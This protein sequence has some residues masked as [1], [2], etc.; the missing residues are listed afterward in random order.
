ML[1]VDNYDNQ[2]G[3]SFLAGEA[4][5]LTINGVVMFVGEV[6]IVNTDVD[7]SKYSKSWMEVTCNGPDHELKQLSATRTYPYSSLT[8]SKAD[9]VIRDFMTLAGCSYTYAS[10]S[11]APEVFLKANKTFQGD[12]FKQICNA[13]GWD[14]YVTNGGVLHFFEEG[15]AG[16]HTSVD[17]L[18]IDGDDTSNILN[19]IEGEENAETVMNYIELSAGKL[20]DH[21][22]E[23]IDGWTGQIGTVVSAEYD[24]VLPLSKA[25]I[26]L[27]RSIAG[28]NQAWIEFPYGGYT[29]LGLFNPGKGY[30]WTYSE[31]LGQATMN[32]RPAF[33]DYHGNVIEWMH[34][35]ATNDEQGTTDNIYPRIWHQADFPVGQE[36]EIKELGTFTRNKKWCYITRETLLEAGTDYTTMNIDADYAGTPGY[37]RLT[38]TGGSGSFSGY[39]VGDYI[40][41]VDCTNS[42]NDGVYEIKTKTSDYIVGLWQEL[43]GDTAADATVN[44]R[45]AFRWQKIDRFMITGYPELQYGDC[46]ID[47]LTIS[48]HEVI[49]IVESAAS[50]ALYHK[51]MYDETHLEITSQKELEEYNDALLD[52]RKWPLTTAKAWAYGQTGSLYAGQ[53][54]DVHAP[55]YGIAS[56]T[57]Y[58]IIG[59][60]HMVRNKDVS[61]F[62]GANFVTYYDLVKHTA[63]GTQRVDPHRF[64]YNDAPNIAVQEEIRRRLDA[65]EL[66]IQPLD[67]EVYARLPANGELESSIYYDTEANILASTPEEDG[68]MAYSTDTKKWFGYNVIDSD[69]DW[70]ELSRAEAVTRL[71]ELAEKNHDSTAGSSDNDKHHNRSHNSRHVTVGG[72]DDLDT[73][74]TGGHEHDYNEDTGPAEGIL[75][76]QRIVGG[77]LTS[78]SLSTLYAASSSGILPTVSFKA[79]SVGAALSS[80]SLDIQLGGHYHE[81]GGTTYDGPGGG[82]THDHNVTT[83]PNSK[84]RKVQGAG[85]IIIDK[86]NIKF[87]LLNTKVIIPIKFPDQEDIGWTKVY[88]NSDITPKRLI[89]QLKQMWHDRAN[90]VELVKADNLVNPKKILPDVLDWDE[91]EE[92]KYMKDKLDKANTDYN[93]EREALKLKKA[94]EGI[95]ALFS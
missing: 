71:N 24:T 61:G 68:M 12:L 6:E 10:P 58:R 78:G 45:S 13:I 55:P 53:S 15:G 46:L 28:D 72:A 47:Y 88:F 83:S 64:E 74:N 41:L 9:D 40:Q 86:E 49:D 60:K 80:T 17:L 89:K 14:G 65:L 63:V 91:V 94:A 76:T 67:P 30:F 92:K 69:D 1:H 32:I 48:S 52:R 82:G 19:F 54:L 87:N 4:V 34:E 81:A 42:A 37:A 3:G 33:R 56:L 79:L 93:E 16:A 11:A 57:K 23:E 62:I 43:A 36:Q 25:S 20:K 22:T 31:M 75:S 5:S 77:V 27:T 95:N 51:R 59:L 2:Y 7:A 35:A 26:R 73:N 39:V 44:F 90:I 8:T 50:Q 38:L 70:D 29:Y 84:L 85:K 18:S 66:A 21:Y